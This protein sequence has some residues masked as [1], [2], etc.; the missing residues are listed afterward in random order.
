MLDQCRKAYPRYT[1]VL[2]M[3]LWPWT[4]IFGSCEK[5]GAASTLTYLYKEIRSFHCT[6]V[7]LKVKEDSGIAGSKFLEDATSWSRSD[8]LDSLFITLLSIVS[9]ISIDETVF[10]SPFTLLMKTIT[11]SRQY[12]SQRTWRECETSPRNLTL[13]VLSLS[14]Y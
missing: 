9:T 12:R 4:V 10:L 5:R 14:C 13:R 6:I 8:K 2:Q 3:S 7:G 11:E 1:K